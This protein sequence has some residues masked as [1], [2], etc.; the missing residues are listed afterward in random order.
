MAAETFNIHHST[1]K[2]QLSVEKRKA[3]FGTLSVALLSTK[4]ESD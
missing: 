1:V 3:P 2:P 4:K